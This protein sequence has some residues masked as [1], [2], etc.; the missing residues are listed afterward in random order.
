MANTRQIDKTKK[1]NIKCEHCGYF[2]RE[3]EVRLSPLDMA[4]LCE[5]TGKPKHYWNRCKCFVWADEMTVNEGM[6][7]EH[8]KTGND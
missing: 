7:S 3:R 8:G 4:N 5:K 2:N 6:E 1:S